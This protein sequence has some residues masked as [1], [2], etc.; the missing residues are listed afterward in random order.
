MVP[1]RI[2]LIVREMTHKH[3]RR[4]TEKRTHTRCYVTEKGNKKK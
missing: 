4:L 3:I 1:N 2:V